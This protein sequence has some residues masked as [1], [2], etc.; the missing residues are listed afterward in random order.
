MSRF[1]DPEKWRD[2]WFRNLTINAKL[3]VLY[4]NDSCDCAGIYTVDH[5][6]ID[7][8]V[9]ISKEEFE[10]S[11]LS[12]NRG[13]IRVITEKTDF[14]WVKNFIQLQ[15]NLPLNHKVGAHRG[16]VRSLHKVR[17][18]CPAIDVFLRDNVRDVDLFL[19]KEYAF[20]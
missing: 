17:S 8:Q 16:I 4:L 19:S 15:K 3:V 7:F 14:I 1:T 10:K 20:P 13:Y 11:Y 9:G 5:Q 6:T 12:L 18:I 2:P